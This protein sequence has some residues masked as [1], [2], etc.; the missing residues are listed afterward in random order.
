MESCFT[1]SVLSSTLSWLD[2][3]DVRVNESSVVLTVGRADG[4]CEELARCDDRVDAT[5]SHVSLSAALAIDP[6]N[7]YRCDQDSD[8]GQTLY[9]AMSLC[10]TEHARTYRYALH[11]EQAVFGRLLC[12]GA[13]MHSRRASRIGH[14]A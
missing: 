14:G 10:N 13:V 1:V 7:P 9:V 5:E 11:P 2:S 4:C 12:L 8:I 6:A 3:F